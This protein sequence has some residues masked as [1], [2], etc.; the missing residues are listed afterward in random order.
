M[1][2]LDVLLNISNNSNLINYPFKYC[3]VDNN[4]IPYTYKKTICR[5]NNI[6][7]FCSFDT[8]ITISDLDKYKGVGVSIQG[9]NVCAID[10]DHCFEKPFDIST[11][12]PIIQPIIDL[13]KNECYIEF[14]F[15]GT[16]LRIF[17]LTDIT[18]NNYQNDYYIKNSK[19]GIEFYT[20]YFSYRYVTITGK[21]IFNNPIKILNINKIY[22]FLNNYMIREK[23]PHVVKI[24]KDNKRLE[25]CLRDIKKLYFKNAD[26]QDLWFGKAPGSNKNES[27][28]DYKLICYL[29]ENITS[30]IETI[31]DLFLNSPYYKSKDYKHISKFTKNNYNYFYYVIN[32]I[33]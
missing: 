28:L 29:Y 27:E 14:S 7:D 30:N 19:K 32:K 12:S 2:A 9:S 11:L 22:E 4:K 18:I 8:L 24:N 23:K 26:F 13:L 3:L 21:Y 20:P 10:I 1:N 31:K 5:P 16:G 15:S 6:E 25:E 33:I 17:F